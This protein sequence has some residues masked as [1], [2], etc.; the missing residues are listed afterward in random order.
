M[1]NNAS[2]LPF[3]SFNG[4]EI[5]KIVIIKAFKA[6]KNA[7]GIAIPSLFS[8]N[9]SRYPSGTLLSSN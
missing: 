1:I 7:S 9:R 2:I 3:L 4:L 6:P 5:K 8:R